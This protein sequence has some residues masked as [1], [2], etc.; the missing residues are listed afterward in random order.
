M[1]DSMGSKIFWLR[2]IMAGS[3][4]GESSVIVHGESLPAEGEAAGNYSHAVERMKQNMRLLRRRE[5][6]EELEICCAKLGEYT[7]KHDMEALSL[8]YGMAV[9]ILQFITEKDL[10]EK[11]SF[12]IGL[13]KLL[14]VGEHDTWNEAGQYLLELSERIFELLGVGGEDNLNNQIM[15]RLLRYM[16]E[17]LEQDLTLIK[18]AQ[19]SGFNASYLSRL[20]KQVKGMTISEYLL[21]KRMELAKEYLG[22]S[23]EKVKNIALKTGY[24]SAQSFA[25]AFHNYAGVSPQEYR[26]RTG[27]EK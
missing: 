15:D 17:H 18:L 14:E 21:M 25:R 3:L 1:V 23:N 2:K 22:A 7:S 16:D 11:L 27:A 12:H 8:Y 5:Y 9:D 10:H 6:F 24:L 19:F 13:Y 4:G 26:I 20:F